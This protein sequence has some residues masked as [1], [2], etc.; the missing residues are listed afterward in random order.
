MCA[1]ACRVHACVCVCVCV[2]VMCVC[3]RVCVHVCASECGWIDSVCL[4]QG[5]NG[6][7]HCECWK[8][9]S[10]HWHHQGTTEYVWKLAVEQRPKR[11]WEIVR[12]CTGTMSLSVYCIVSY[13]CRYKFS[14]KRWKSRFKNSSWYNFCKWLR[15]HTTPTTYFA[16]SIFANVSWHANIAKIIPR[17]SYQLYGIWCVCVYMYKYIFSTYVCCL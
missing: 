5:W 4:I 16:V 9:P 15:T 17:E 1:C 3:A 14:Q 2:S 7:G 8:P 11:H 10:L 12:V 6:H 13:F